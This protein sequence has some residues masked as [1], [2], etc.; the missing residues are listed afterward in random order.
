L[1]A[2]RYRLARHRPPGPPGGR[3]AQLGQLG[4]VRFL[5]VV[6]DL[7]LSDHLLLVLR[8]LLGGQVA[9]LGGRA[10]QDLVGR[11]PGRGALL[12]QRFQESRQGA[13]SIIPI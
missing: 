3:G 12:A 4:G 9:L 2:G 8:Q 6:V 11:G 5:D 1:L 7:V 13:N 10:G